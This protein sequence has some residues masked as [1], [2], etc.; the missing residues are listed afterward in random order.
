[1]SNLP[2]GMYIIKVETDAG[3]CIK[4]IIKD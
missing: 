4:K 3:D 2:V 1:M